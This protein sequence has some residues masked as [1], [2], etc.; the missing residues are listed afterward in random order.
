[1]GLSDEILMKRGGDKEMCAE[2]A[3]DFSSESVTGRGGKG[4]ILP[5]VSLGGVKDK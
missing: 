5:R 4:Q 3:E 2:W 1:L